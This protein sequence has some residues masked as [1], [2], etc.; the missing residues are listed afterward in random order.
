MA[1]MDAYI[2]RIKRAWTF[3]KLSDKEKKECVKNLCQCKSKDA[4]FD[5]FS[6]YLKKLDYDPSLWGEDDYHRT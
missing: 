3:N 5:C 4:V 1:G 2:E 6:K